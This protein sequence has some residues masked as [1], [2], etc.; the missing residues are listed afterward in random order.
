MDELERELKRCERILGNGGR[1]NFSKEKKLK[2]IRFYY[3]KHLNPKPYYIVFRMGKESRSF[4]NG[5]L[6]KEYSN[7]ATYCNQEE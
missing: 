7:L 4:E 6:E 5:S 3:D 1:E 2:I